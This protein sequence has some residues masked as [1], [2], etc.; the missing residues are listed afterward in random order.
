MDALISERA[1]CLALIGIIT[2]TVIV[3]LWAIV[4]TERGTFH[5][6]DHP[7]RISGRRL[8]EYCLQPKAVPLH[9]KV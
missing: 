7:R 4:K 6:R 5:F 1:C 8:S 2:A 9:L 3:L